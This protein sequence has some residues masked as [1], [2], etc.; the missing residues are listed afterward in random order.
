MA[1]LRPFLIEG[2]T[3]NLSFFTNFRHFGPS[4]EQCVSEVEG[5]KP[6]LCFFSIFAFC[7]GDEAIELAGRI[8][9]RLGSLPVVFG[10][11][12]VCANPHYFLKRSPIDFVLTGEA[13]I[14][15]NRFVA[16]LSRPEPNFSKV[17]NL[18]WK[19]DGEIRTSPL[20]LVPS[21]DQI[22]VGLVKSSESS[23]TLTV[24]A[25]LSRGCPKKC[26]FCSSHLVFGKS[27]RT[28]PLDQISKAIDR[29]LIDHNAI[30]KQ[31]VIN[32]E[33]DNLLADEPFLKSVVLAL[34][35]QIPGVKFIAENG[36][37]Y[38]FITPELC[39]WLI[40]NGMEKFNLSLAS[41]DPDILQKRRRFLHLETFEGVIGMLATHGIPSVTYFICGFKE[42]TIETTAT[43][44]TY[45]ANKET[46]IG[47]SMFYPVPGLPGFSDLTV[48]DSAPSSL[49]LGSAAFPWNNSISTETMLT[50]FRLS[51]YIN[52]LKNLPRLEIEN[53][54]LD[55]IANKQELHTIIREKSGK[56]RIIAVPKQDKEL[57]KL[58]IS[59]IK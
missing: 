36:I 51:R 15:L 39:E 43:N 25:S 23:R 11:G 49:C 37:D 46:L 13:E 57:I 58:V 42:D 28:V 47:I 48:F 50:A 35:K 17:P 2:E 53:Q 21:G 6:D 8:K 55:T 56:E 41:L 27:F 7:Y 4:L 10:G 16:E 40:Q 45:L 32:I 31:I 5:F 30:T 59:K 26:S 18:Q 54:L 9:K 33:D 38:S 19:E 44:L 3:G 1:Y 12:A 14:S 29:F 20:A 24:S 34:Q 22:E 52:L